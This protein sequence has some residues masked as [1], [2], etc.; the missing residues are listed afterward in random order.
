MVDG[1]WVYVLERRVDGT[2][3][4]VRVETGRNERETLA[5]LSNVPDQPGLAV[6]P[7][8]ERVFLTQ[9]ERGDSDIAIIP[10]F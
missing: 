8:G 1:A 4:V 3:L 6:I 7:G 9:V 10:D 5:S 2:A